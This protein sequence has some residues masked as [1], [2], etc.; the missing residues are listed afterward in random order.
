MADLLGNYIPK[1]GLSLAKY[2]GQQIADRLGEEVVRETVA[3]ILC[4]YNLRALTE[5]LTRRRLT[6]SNG[7]MVKTFI[8][9]ANKIDDFPEK[10]SA[11]LSK[12]LKGATPVER[13][14]FLNWIVGLTGKSIQNVLRGASKNLEGYLNNFQDSIEK[15]C[16][17][18]K[19][20]F[21]EIKGELKIG[22]SVALV[23][24][25]FISYLNA[26]IGSQTLAIR[27]SEKSMYGKMFEPLVLSALLQLLGFKRVKESD[28]SQKERVFWLSHRKDKR[29]S[30]ATLLYEAG[31]GVYFDIGFIG[32]GNPEIT[33]DKVSRFERFLEDGYR[34]FEMKTIIIVDRIGDGSRIE[35]LAAKIN[36]HIVQ[37]SM[38]HWVKVIY[39]ILKSTI[40]FKHP[41]LSMQYSELESYIR[42]KVGKIDLKFE[43]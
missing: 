23:D 43:S 32:P 25:L 1:L 28:Y 10:L 41:I 39:E 15:A 31:V 24:W 7:A 35:G 38:A 11:I 36:G 26:A 37:M 17:V 14:I 42:E 2:K 4:G 27:G 40:G 8:D 29:E 33:L 20:E 12:E 18:C 9:A 16:V 22:S 34:K 21:G 13:K 6:L 3:S 5:N 30:D 19:E